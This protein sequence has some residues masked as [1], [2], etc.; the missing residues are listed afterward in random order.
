MKITER[1]TASLKPSDG[2]PRLHDHTGVAAIARSIE[3]YGFRQP[4]VVRR[5]VVVVGHGRLEAAKRL[6]LQTVPCVDA[7]DLSDEEARALRAVDN[8][9]GELSEWDPASL[10]ID[11]AELP[12]D[13]MIGWD[14]AALETIAAWEPGADLGEILHDPL[15]PPPGE[16]PAP[17]PKKKKRK[18]PEPPAPGALSEVCPKCGR[19]W[20]EE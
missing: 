3:R 11:A 7:D 19:P 12:A 4:L 1:P 14:P 9:V 20:T 6:G 15:P 17:A 10:S 13:M 5:G 18:P 16:P 2:N 8:R